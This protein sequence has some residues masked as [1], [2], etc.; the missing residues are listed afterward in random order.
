MLF[1]SLVFGDSSVTLIRGYS[2]RNIREPG[3]APTMRTYEVVGSNSPDFHRLWGIVWRPLDPR[4]SVVMCA[5]C[6]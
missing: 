6:R 2:S 5:T 4:V 3:H 1:R